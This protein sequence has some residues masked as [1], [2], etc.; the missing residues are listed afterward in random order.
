MEWQPIETAPYHGKPLLLWAERNGFRGK[1]RMVV[2]RWYSECARWYITGCGPTTFSEQWLD[3]CTPSHWMP[4]PE[5][6]K[7][8]NK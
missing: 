5:P 1:P 6:P 8:E 3:E 2:G 7:A 4:L